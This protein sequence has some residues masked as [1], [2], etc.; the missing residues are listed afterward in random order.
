[1]NSRAAGLSS[2]PAPQ[3]SGASRAELRVLVVEDLPTDAELMA[4]EL[5]KAG[6]AFDMR[7]VGSEAEFVSALAQ[8]SPDIVL[9]DY[10]LPGFSGMAAL[11]IARKTQPRIPFV[12]VSGSIGEEKAI[13]AIKSG[14][15]DYVLKDNLIRLPHAL[16]R[17]L[18]EAAQR[19]AR[20]ATERALHASEEKNQ[21]FA[22]LV[23][24]SSDAIFSKDLNG[25]VMSW[26]RGASA[27]YGFSAE[28]AIG[29]SVRQ[30]QLAHLSDAEFEQILAR[31]RKGRP[32][33]FE[34]QRSTKAGQLRDVLLSTTPLFARP[35]SGA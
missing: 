21:L 30:L 24:Q 27:L 2:A 7:V 32:Q 26:N 33:S 5:R 28:E 3:E 10:S 15:R 29:T 19:N 1:M 6:V 16:R 35:I 34:T 20:E 9:S 25:V 12:F 13:E 22:T 23:E 18:E 4:R 14:A 11:A 17:A 8:F 31:I